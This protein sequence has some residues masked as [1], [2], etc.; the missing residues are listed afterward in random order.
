MLAAPPR[1]HCLALA[2]AAAPA[3]VHASGLPGEQAGLIQLWLWVVPALLLVI[4]LMGWRMARLAASLRGARATLAATNERLASAENLWGFALEGSDEGMWLWTRESGELTLSPRYKELLGYSADEF[5]P[6]FA[7]WQQQLHPDDRARVDQ[8]MQQLVRSARADGDRGATTEFRMR[9]KNGQWKWVLARGI[10]SAR[11]AK[12]RPVR[13]TGTMADI[14]ERKEAEEARVRSVLA[15][16]ED[17]LRQGEERLQEII[18]VL[19]IGLSI[20]DPQGRVL[21]INSAGEQQLGAAAG[22][23]DPADPAAQPAALDER[24]SEAFAAGQIIDFVATQDDAAG[25]R[26]HLRTLKK[27]VFDEQGRPAYL[28]SITIDITATIDHERQLR[29]LNEHLE[30]RVHQRTEQLDLAKQVAEEASKAKG[31]FLAN[32][33]HEIRTP[34]NGVIGMAYLALKTELDARQR[35]YLEKIRF[36]G[37]HLLGIIDDILDFSRIEAGRLEL[38]QVAFTLADVLR[39]L[40]TMVGPKAASK[41]LA[42][43][44]ELGADLPPVLLGDPRRIGQVLINYVYNAVKFSEHGAITLRIAKLEETEASCLLRFEVSD[45]GIGLSEQEQAKLFRSFQQADTSATRQY[46]G[47][48]LGLAICKQLAQ[49]MGGEVG[50]ES[51]PGRGSSFWFTARLGTLAQL[52]AAQSAAPVGHGVA[53]AAQAAEQAQALRGAHILLVEDNAF[54][55]QIALEILEE[56]GCRVTLAANGVE[57]LGLLRD[58]AVDCV[59]MDVQMPVMD[60]LEATMLIRADARLR[61]LPVIAM[62]ANATHADR[63]ECA[64]CGMDDFLGKPVLPALLCETVARWLPARAAGAAT[65]IAAPERAAAGAFRPLAGDPA[66]IDLAVLAK[67]LDYQPDKVRKFALKFLLST[68]DGVREMERALATGDLERVRE[69]GHRIKSAARMV[70]AIGLAEQC[71]ALETLAPGPRDI[72]RAADGIAQVRE[73]LASIAVRIAEHTSEVAACRAPA[74]EGAPLGA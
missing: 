50:V 57:A 17:A 58:S 45:E 47:T 41:E 35:D 18:Q 11:D 53:A 31:Q 44:F 10:V 38:G 54:N 48:G 56:A 7:L 16:S 8:V 19:P 21:L 55:Q 73:L 39:T 2:L 28:I 65:A 9:A 69:L 61:T 64:R 5:D 36:A 6:P 30:E 60:G 70:G 74:A 37:E 49:L 59:L 67:L 46:G 4:A 25:R 12:G 63:E 33:S 43:V 71:Q 15:R 34:M 20:K 13:I 14:N 1:V 68:E 40:S 23:A 24:D 66:I 22:L 3:A 51:T 32:M 42:L 29:E 72:E 27:P 52:P 26:Q 62:T